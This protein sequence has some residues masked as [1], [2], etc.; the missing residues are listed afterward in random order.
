MRRVTRISV[1]TAVFLIACGTETAPTGTD[2]AGDPADARDGSTPD[3]EP[4]AIVADLRADA[5]R[6]GVVSF[7]DEADDDGEDVWDSK[8]GAVFLA[9]ID[10]DEEV[11]DPD[12]SDIEVAACNDA[13]DDEVNGPDDALDLARIKTKPWPAV[14]KGATGTITWTA[15]DHVRLFKVKDSSFTAVESGVK[16]T[17]SDLE[18]GVELAIEGKDILRDGEWDGYVDVTLE[19]DAEGKSRTDKV[20][21]RIAPLL[22]YHHLLPTEQTWVSASGN[23]GN[24]DMRAGLAEA[25]AAAGLPAVRGVDTS[26]SWNQDYFETGFMSMP[27]TGG[28]QHAIRVNIRSANVRHPDS[29][30]N[31]LRAAGRIVWLL[32][33]KDTAGVQQFKTARTEQEQA[34]DSLNSFG[35]LETVPP[36]SWSG[37]SFPLGRVI[38]GQTSTVYPD[39]MFTAMMEAQKVQPPIYVDTSWLVV[40]HI[41]ETVS[42]VKASNARGWVMLVNDAAMAK[43]MFQ[44]R[45]DAGQ[46]NT[47]LHVGKFWGV[48]GDAPAQVTID[49]VLSDTDVMAASAEAAVEVAAQVAKI[50]QET[51]LTDAE[52]IKVPF[53]HE[54]LN[55]SS[56]AYQPGMVNGI[57]ISD[58]HFVVPDPHGPVIDGQDIFKQAMIAAL[59]PFDITVHFAEDWDT[60]HRQ[61]GEV[62]C[63]TNS[64]RQIPSAKWWESG[65]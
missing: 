17:E 2:P 34:H 38:R 55:G 44:A 5:N 51:G 29:P 43:D 4:G 20:R 56:V 49:E 36:Y 12:L 16:L 33:G 62:H 1:L 63:G 61:H 30:A 32:R 64:T 37:Q 48:S 47:P 42:F 60:Y 53:L 57:Y 28:K 52:I 22:T 14:P 9:N 3:E 40:G 13:A 31:P 54:T 10:D 50:K 27:A 58:T 46:G 45:S 24:L 39:E 18:S 8:R 25:L 7:D 19:V 11:C 23:Q 35:N 6:D 59:A 21:M 41:D 26:D 15:G 65:R